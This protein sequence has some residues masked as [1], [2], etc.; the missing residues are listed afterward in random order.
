MGKTSKKARAKKR[1]Q[2]RGS[3]ASVAAESSTRIAPAQAVAVAQSRGRTDAVVPPALTSSDDTEPS[4]SSW[5]AEQTSAD[6]GDIALERAT[7]AVDDEHRAAP[8]VSVAVEI[9]LTSESHFF[10]GLSGDIS[11]GG[12]FVSTY[13]PLSTGS[14]VDLE[15]SLPGS[16]APVK[17]RGEVR[18]LREHSQHEPR[19]VGIAFEDLAPEDR[20]RIHEFCSVR[21][22]LYYDVG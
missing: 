14:S 21:P 2:A 9:H 6:R 17:A 4:P 13:R 10:S 8:R 11:E 19:G 20:A 1:K 18:W 16:S 22:A 3:L 7:R 12:L 5:L 15:F